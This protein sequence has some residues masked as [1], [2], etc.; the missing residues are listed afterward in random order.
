MKSFILTI[1]TAFAV[2]AHGSVHLPRLEESPTLDHRAQS[3]TQTCGEVSELVPF[4]EVYSPSLTLHYYTTF[5]FNVT[6]YITGDT[7][8]FLGVAALIF[9][10]PD[11]STVPFYT[12]RSTTHSAYFFTANETERTQALANGYT[13]WNT[14][15]YI[16]PEQICGSVPLYR[17]HLVATNSDY[18]YTTST[19]ERDDA[20]FNKGFTYEGIAGYVLNCCRV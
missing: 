12:L 10:F 6:A 5:D 9:P 3:S 19:A 4:F 16:Y 11:T 20:I 2:V 15:G 18:M 1:L 14:A 7:A 8:M 13:N 17:L